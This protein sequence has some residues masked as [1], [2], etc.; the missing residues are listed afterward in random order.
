MIRRANSPMQFVLEH[1]MSCY[2]TVY[3]VSGWV[4]QARPCESAASVRPLLLASKSPFIISLFG[5]LLSTDTSKLRRATQVAQLELNARKSVSGFFANITVQIDYIFSSLRRGHR[6]YF[7]HCVQPSANM[8]SVSSSREMIDVS[9]VRSQIRSILL[10]D[11]IRVNN[12]GY[13]ERV[14]FRDFRRRFGCLIEDELS[15]SLNNALDDRAAVSRI[16]ERM[17]I[18]PSRYRLGISQIL[19]AADVMNELEDRRELS[20]SGLVTAF[21]HECRK[22]LAS[23]WLH[24]RR[25][26]ETAIKCI[27]KNGKAYMRV[28]EW[29][30]WKLYTKIVP[31]LAATRSD[32]SHHECELR[33]RQLEQQLHLL[34]VEKTRQEGQ[35]C[36]LEERLASEMQTTHELTQALNRETQTTVEINRKL[37]QCRD[38]VPDDDRISRVSSVAR[39]ESDE[40]VAELKAEL[41]RVQQ[42]EEQ[43]RAKT[44]RVVSQLKD[45]E[46]ELN[47]IRARNETLEKKQQRFDADIDAVEK[48]LKEM[49]E[50][51]DKAEKERDDLRM[52]V[53]RKTGEIQDLKTATSELRTTVARLERRSRRTIGCGE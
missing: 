43:M 46:V 7:I 15:S 25:V 29:P 32:P 34:R 51:K 48:Q 18:H 3:D 2:P 27:Q 19:L 50:S 11:S 1:A 42:A 38:G 37:Q 44:Q 49:R 17:D 35:I 53:S 24:H 9:F 12:R 22:Y 10:I 28:R 39:L 47:N 52:S 8:R 6:S 36:D 31:L 23:K 14:P 16:L 26:L 40:K 21:Q 5:S 4:K 33:V 41:A 13:P 30:W 45:V 20:L